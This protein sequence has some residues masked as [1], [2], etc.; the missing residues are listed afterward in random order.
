M[1]D[2]RHLTAQEIVCAQCAGSYRRGLGGPAGRTHLSVSLH[3][4]EGLHQAQSLL[5]RPAHRQVVHTHVLH[6][7]IGI[8]D[9]EAPDDDTVSITFIQHIQSQTSVFN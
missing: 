7:A 6:H 3:I 1:K 2:R 4:L 5:H 9:E 8:N